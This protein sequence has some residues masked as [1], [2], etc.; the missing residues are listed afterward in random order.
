[1][2]ALLLASLLWLPLL[3]VGAESA[4]L[5]VAIDD[6]WPPFRMSDASGKLHGLDIDLLDELSRRTGLRFEI[7]VVPWAR[8]LA[9]VRHG[10]AQMITGLARTAERETY[11]DYLQPS[12]YA[13][14]PRFYGPPQQARAISAYSQ[15]RGPRIGYVLESAYFPAFDADSAL[16]KVGVKNEQQLLE[17]QLH[18]RVDLLVGTDCQLDYQLRDPQLARQLV[19]LAYRPEATTQ[20]FIGFSRQEARPREQALIGTA[21]RQLLAEGWLK[22]AARRYWGTGP[23]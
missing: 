16:T 17:M 13:C 18:G 11:I 21:L 12:Y 3:A 22:Q 9:A 10:Q 14:S 4:P 23:Q 5:H 8:A 6:N 20:L 2:R 15:L 19:K 1:M 7:Q